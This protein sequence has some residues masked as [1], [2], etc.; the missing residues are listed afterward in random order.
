MTDSLVKHRCVI[1]IEDYEPV[2]VAQQYANF[3]KGLKRFSQTW[4][5]TTRISPIKMEGDGAIAVWNIETEAPNWKVATEFR[6]LKWSD[7]IGKEFRLWN[8]DGAWRAI[9]AIFDC[10]RSGTFW[11]YFRLNWRFG[12]LFFYP[13]LAVLSFTAVAFWLTGMLGTFEIPYA[14]FLGFVIAAALFIAFF[15]WFDRI[16]LPHVVEMWIVL[17]ELVY[18]ERTNLTE[19]LGIFS[20]DITE[21]LESNG[22]DEIV[23]VGHGIGAVLQ[24]VIVDRAFWALPEFGKD[25]R[26]VSL[27]SL[28][29]LLLAVG[30]HPEASTVV[31]PVARIARDR[32]VYWAEYQSRE[33]VFSFPGSNPVTELIGEFGKPVLQNIRFKD[34]IGTD[35]RRQFSRIV[36]GNHRQFIRANSKRYFYDFFM[37]CCGPFTLSMRVEHPEHM[38]DCFDPDG[39]LILSTR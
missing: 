13:V 31:G 36:F 30:L 27:L 24:P 25:G 29:S 39:R 32:W 4:N 28:G 10:V 20:R 17:H 11:R 9:K 3:H 26:S 7:T 18:L 35:T 22:F 16:V 2:D 14:P 8:L 1:L 6:L 33:D 19:R 34:M 38:V 23:I 21:K 37:V 15:E 12:L 5:V